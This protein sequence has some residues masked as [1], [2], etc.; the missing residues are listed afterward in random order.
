MKKNILIIGFILCLGALSFAQQPPAN[1]TNEQNRIATI[2]NKL[3]LFAVDVPALS[4]PV[5]IN[6]SNTKQVLN[7]IGQVRFA[8]LLEVFGS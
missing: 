6:I 1:T 2:E 7:Q 8:N 3:K 5:N 4:D